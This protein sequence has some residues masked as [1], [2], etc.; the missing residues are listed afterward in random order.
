MSDRGSASEP[1][2]GDELSRDAHLDL[3]KAPPRE[4]LDA[5]GVAQLVLAELAAVDEHLRIDERGAR[6]AVS[7]VRADGE[8]VQELSTAGA[9]ELLAGDAG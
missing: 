1:G 7:V 9:L 8:L 5:L 4:V 3:P 2:D 6:V